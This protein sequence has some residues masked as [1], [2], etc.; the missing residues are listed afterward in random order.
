MPARVIDKGILSARLLAHV[1]IAKYADHLPPYRQESIFDRAGLSIPR[2]TLAQWVGVSG[3]QL[4]PFVDALRD[5]VLGQHVIHPDETPVQMLTPGAKKTHRAYVWAYATSQF[6]DLAAVVTTSDPAVP[7][8]MHATSRK[9]G[10]AS[11]SATILVVTRPA[12]NS[13]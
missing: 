4:Q 2:S 10:K 11:W 5:V 13:A 8:S 1:M 3:V 9:T 7:E 12:L 6:S